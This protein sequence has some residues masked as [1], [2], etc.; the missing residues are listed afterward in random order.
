MASRKVLLLIADIGGYTKFIRAHKTSLA[1]A[2][3]IVHELLES[4]VQ[5]ARGSFE[6]SKLEGDAV[7]LFTASDSPSADLT[8]VLAEMHRAFHAKQQMIEE[9]QIC[10][11]A[12]C[13]GTGGLKL[14]VVAH[15]GEALVR[16]IRH[17]HELTGECVIVVHRMLKN[18][19]PLREYVLFSDEL[20]RAAN[21]ETQCRLVATRLNMEG[22]GEVPTAYLDL[23]QL[24]GEIP[25]AVR[26]PWPMRFLAYVW[27]GVLAI[28][29]RLGMKRPLE[30]FHNIPE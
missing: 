19:V 18:E 3:L 2:D 29:F 23:S 24:A 12:A 6:L 15:R 11:C 13:V 8:P 28:P 30:D 16:K 26:L 5:A 1:H 7:F 21:A 25:P 9:N 22:F 14:K 20:A 27:H 4:V 17:C 10:G